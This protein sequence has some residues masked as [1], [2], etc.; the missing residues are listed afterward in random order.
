MLRDLIELRRNGWVPRKSATTEAPVPMQQLRP[1]DNDTPFVNTKRDQRNIDRDSDS[2]MSKTQFNYQP[3]VNSYNSPL[4]M[5]NL[6]SMNQSYN[7]PVGGGYNN[8]DYRDGGNQMGN[9]G[10]RGG[11]DR[12]NDRN[13]DRNADRMDRDLMGGSRG[14]DGINR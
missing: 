5:N 11:I 10:G 9:V 6:Y 2:W 1:D 13:M 4:I 7:S 14:G 3:N 8:R 12:N